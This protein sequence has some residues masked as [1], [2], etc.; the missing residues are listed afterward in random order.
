MTRICLRC[1][2][3][4]NL[5]YEAESG[6]ESMSGQRGFLLVDRHKVLSNKRHIWCNVAICPECGEVSIY[7]EELNKLKD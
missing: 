5:N 3:E 6:S 2:S 1:G 4:M 7:T